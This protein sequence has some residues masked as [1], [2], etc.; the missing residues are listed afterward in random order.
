[1]YASVTLPGSPRGW[2]SHTTTTR[3]PTMLDADVEITLSVVI[4]VGAR[5]ADIAQL[6][7][8]YKAALE[9]V[10][11]QHEIIFVLDGRHPDVTAALDALQRRGEEF[12]V[13]SL[14]RAF[15]ESTT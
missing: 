11:Y 6:Y 1:M 15:G 8:N 5:H 13:V 3:A 7:A 14:T 10:P 12:Q 4:P 9:Q 2:S